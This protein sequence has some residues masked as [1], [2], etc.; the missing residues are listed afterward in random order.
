VTLRV[1]GSAV[2]LLL[3]AGTIFVLR[4]G[5]PVFAPLL[6]SVLLAYALEP[7]VA[8]LMRLRMPR[9]LAVVVLYLIIAAAA[10]GLARIAQTQ[11]NSF[12]DDLPATIRDLRTTL[13][14]TSSDSPGWLERLQRAAGEVQATID[15]TAAPV[16]AGVKRV[17]ADQGHFDIR[18]TVRCIELACLNPADR[19]ECRVYNQFTE[20]FSVL[21][22]AH[23]VQHT[24]TRMGLKVTIDHLPDPRVEKEEHYYNAKHSKLV[25]LGL[26]PH[27]LSESLLDSLLNIAQRYRDRIDQSMFIPR[28]DWRKARNDR[29]HTTVE[30]GAAR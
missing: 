24:A 16:A 7:F 28:V 30:T 19:G 18:D 20:Q 1:R 14:K 22:L 8:A 5:E 4:E 29:H 13:A 21:E 27:L 6:V 9:V 23:L 11:A 26:E 15:A 3:V 17:S 12:V 10:I 25:D 2:G